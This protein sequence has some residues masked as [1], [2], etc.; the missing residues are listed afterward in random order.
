MA[1]RVHLA[2]EIVIIPIARKKLEKRGIQQKWVEE[3]IQKPTQ[4]VPGYGGRTVYQRLY[5]KQGQKEQLLRVICEVNENKYVVISVYL[6]SD[7]KR[8]RRT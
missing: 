3:T 7:I 4:T 2:V 5:Q 8:Y 6:T 1:S